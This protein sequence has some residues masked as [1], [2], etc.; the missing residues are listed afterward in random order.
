MISW[1]SLLLPAG[2]SGYTGPRALQY[3][4]V[5]NGYDVRVRLLAVRGGF[6]TPSWRR[7]RGALIVNH[8][9]L[10]SLRASSPRP[11]HHH[12]DHAHQEQRHHH[13]QDYSQDVCQSKSFGSWKRENRSDWQTVVWEANSAG[14]S[15]PTGGRGRLASTRWSRGPEITALILCPQILCWHYRS[16]SFSGTEKNNDSFF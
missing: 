13:A 12:Y 4:T 14:R 16:K 2:A 9:H 6:L 7:P 10:G 11:D 15:G 5:I 3:L 1:R 8:L